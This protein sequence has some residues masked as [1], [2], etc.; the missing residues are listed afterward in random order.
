MRINRYKARHKLPKGFHDGSIAAVS[1]IRRAPTR[2]DVGGWDLVDTHTGSLIAEYNDDGGSDFHEMFKAIYTLQ[3]NQAMAAMKL[4]G[5]A[6]A[7]HE[8]SK[9]NTVIATITNAAYVTLPQT[10]KLTR[11]QAFDGQ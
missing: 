5:G 2:R 8:H 4:I 6:T 3:V 9:N 1:I 10:M 11:K 7:E